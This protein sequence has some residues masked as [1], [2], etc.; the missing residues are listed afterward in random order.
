LV[1]LPTGI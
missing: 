1:I